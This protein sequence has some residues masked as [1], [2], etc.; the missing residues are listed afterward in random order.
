MFLMRE[1]ICFS[2]TDMFIFQRIITL[3]IRGLGYIIKLSLKKSN[4]KYEDSDISCETSNC[5]IRPRNYQQNL[6]DDVFRLSK[7]IVSQ[8]VGQCRENNFLTLYIYHT[9]LIIFCHAT[10]I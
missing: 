10:F 4:A 3:N 2:Y 5:D 8:I 1:Q 7:V 9:T 6:Y